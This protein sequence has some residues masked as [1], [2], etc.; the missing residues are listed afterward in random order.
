MLRSVCILVIASASLCL[1]ADEP[2]GTKDAP[3]VP[4]PPLVVTEM[5]RLADV[6]PKDVVYDLGCGDGRIVIEAAKRFAARGVGVDID[7]RRIEESNVNGKK[8]GISDRVQFF[9]KNLF[10]MDFS[11]ATVVALYL[12]PEVNLKLRPKLLKE[13]KPGSR[14]VCHQ[15][16][17]GDWKP[18]ATALVDC[19][20]VYL[21][22]IPATQ[23]KN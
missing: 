11:D 13:L 22:I 7:P 5:L 1:A 12:V 2:R 15:F 3:Y 21:Y 14:I 10:D 19:R 4:T 17:M 18:T 20:W 23:G 6:G 8:A 16:D 9:T